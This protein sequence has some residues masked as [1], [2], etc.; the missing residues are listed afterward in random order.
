VSENDL[1][2]LETAVQQSLSQIEPMDDSQA[3]ANRRES[4]QMFEKQVT[5]ARWITG[6]FLAI[7][8]AAMVAAAVFLQYATSTQ[9][10]IWCVIMFL[11][12]FEGTILIKLWYWVISSKI[13]VLKEIKELE[14]LLAGQ[15]RE[16]KP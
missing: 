8:I 6:L 12:A 10:M 7:E 11:V 15:L 1:D 14:I 4:I 13:R 3:D 2:E 5:K 9:M 16:K